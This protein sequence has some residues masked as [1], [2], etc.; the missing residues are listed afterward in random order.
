[1]IAKTTQ[2]VID[3][4]QRVE[5]PAESRISSSPSLAP[6]TSTESSNKSRSPSY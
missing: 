1:M 2:S 4:M 6:S 3:R 5:T